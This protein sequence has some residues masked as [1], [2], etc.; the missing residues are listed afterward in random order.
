M[1]C[2]DETT[3]LCGLCAE[4][5][6]SRSDPARAVWSFGDT[7]AIRGLAT[8]FT[9]WARVASQCDAVSKA[10]YKALRER[11]HSHGRA[12]RSV[13]DR[14]LNIACSMLRSRTTFNPSFANEKTAC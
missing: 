13:A 10:K 14:L 11:G 7:P 4:S 2:G 6:R 3:L 9:T 1:P 8:Q 5:R 12:L